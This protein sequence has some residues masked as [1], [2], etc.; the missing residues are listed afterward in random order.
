MK[1]S[2]DA[3]LFGAWFAKKKLR[4]TEIL[5]IGSGTG[6][7]MLMLA[8]KQDSRISGIEIDATCFEQLQENIKNS[9]WK[10]RLKV[11]TGDVRS[12]ITEI[13]F[14]FIITN[15]PFFENSLKAETNEANLAR[16]SKALRFEELILSIDRLLAENGH[17]GVL[18][19]FQR[20]AEFE[21]LAALR[22]FH[23]LEKLSVRQS[24]THQ[25]FRSILHYSR[26]KS[27]NV[28]EEELI[29]VKGEGEYTQEFIQL[30]RDYYLY[31]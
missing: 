9:E 28:S 27:S 16:H 25:Y 12:F 31:L 11:F 10:E 18:L 7:L 4:A 13:K 30:L 3:C 21:K 17:F 29:I 14:D 6:L 23:L 26:I 22:G 24:P 19:P 20:T 1:V 5:D 8:Q 2:T 15:P